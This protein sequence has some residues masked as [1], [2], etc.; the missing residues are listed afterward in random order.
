MIECYINSVHESDIAFKRVL[1]YSLKSEQRFKNFVC[2]NIYRP[3][4]Y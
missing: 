1:Y 4:Y 3:L 2:D